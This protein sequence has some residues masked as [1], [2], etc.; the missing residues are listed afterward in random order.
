MSWGMPPKHKIKHQFNNKDAAT[1]LQ[2]CKKY[3]EEKG[4][5]ITKVGAYAIQAEKRMGY[6]FYGFISM[7]GRPWIDVSI[8]VS[9]DGLLTLDSY[10]NYRS[11]NSMAI[12]DSGRQKKEL[13]HI[14]E[15]ISTNA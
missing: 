9:K 2:V 3:L 13:S 8:L 15:Y 6:T 4:F 12:N 14:V 10:Y 11:R 5:T 7:S 1:M